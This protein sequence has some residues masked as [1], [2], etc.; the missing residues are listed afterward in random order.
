MRDAARALQYAHEKGTVHRDLKPENFMVQSKPKPGANSKSIE[1]CTHHLFVMDFG[2]ARPS[3]A[4]T[5][6]TIP[7]TVM[8][9]P[10][11]MS[12]EQASGREVDH[13]TDVYALGAT[14]YDRL[15]G[16]PPFES[17]NIFE[18]LRL[19]Q[20]TMPQRPSAID[21]TIDSKLEAIVMKTLEKDPGKRYQSATEL[22][23]ALEGWLREHQPEADA[24]AG[25]KK[26]GCGKAAVFLL[27]AGA[28]LLGAM[29]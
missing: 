19:V 12:P 4:S 20:E 14:L 26:G 18:G 16:R 21:P 27:A 9:S 22:A 7:G 1:G 10:S 23:E 13:R 15:C 5:Q 17:K 2:I 8:G 25:A 24:P 29:A 28:A 6:L 11:F 3:D